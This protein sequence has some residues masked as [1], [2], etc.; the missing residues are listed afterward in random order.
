MYDAAKLVVGL[1]MMLLLVTFFGFIPFSLLLF[2]RKLRVIGMFVL[3][4][5]AAYILA[6]YIGCGFYDRATKDHDVLTYVLKLH[7][8]ILANEVAAVF[9]PPFHWKDEPANEQKENYWMVRRYSMNQAVRRMVF[10]EPQSGYRVVTIY[11]DN[12][13][14]LIGLDISASSGRKLRENDLR[15][16]QELFQCCFDHLHWHQT[17]GELL[18]CPFRTSHLNTS[19]TERRNDKQ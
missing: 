11:F 6:S 2:F 16:P 14:T 18:S 1:L 17:Q 3:S 12:N 4:V 10:L 15:F 9:P 19:D 5:S 13:D 7:P 8:G